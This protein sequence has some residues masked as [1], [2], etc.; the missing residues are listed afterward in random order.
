[1]VVIIIV[2]IISIK[3]KSFQEME[4]LSLDAKDKRKSE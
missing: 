1:M 4:Q 3:K 2:T